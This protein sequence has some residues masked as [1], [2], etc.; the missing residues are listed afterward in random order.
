MINLIKIEILKL[1]TSP[2]FYATAIAALVLSLG[3][4]ITNV[5]VKPEHGDPPIGSANNAQ[6]VLSQAGAVGS[7]AIFILGILV[8]AGEYR[9][10]TIMGAFLAQPRRL[11]V[12]VAKMALMGV[13]GA[14]LGAVIYTITT[15][16]AVSLYA[17]KGVH[18]LPV[19]LVDLG[20]GTVMSGACY[21]LLGVAVGALARNTVA[22]VIGGIVWIQ[23]FEVAVLENVAPSFAKWL[24]VGA[25][26]GLTS[27]G[28][29]LHVLSRPAAAAV[30]VVWAACLVLLA[31]A[32]ST[33]REL[34]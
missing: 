34:R 20:L 8:V 13:V 24:P 4:S 21:G 6:D 29:S 19:S 31:G 17:S 10:R 2:A 22:A 27:V 23:V 26:R 11:R 1:R 14:A 5:L 15:T 32:I 28:S 30:L 25:A 12:I 7:Q 9:H 16:A 18:H 3:S 33:R